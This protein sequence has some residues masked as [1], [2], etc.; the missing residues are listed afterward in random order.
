VAAWL[1]KEKNDERCR[2]P[3]GSC[4]YLANGEH[5][6]QYMLMIYHDEE[7]RAKMLEAQQGKI[8]QECDEFAQSLVKSDHFRAGARLQPTSM[9]TTVREKS[10]KRVT[11][12]GP[13]AESKE[14][15]AGYL[16]VECEDL[17]E[18]LAIAARFPSIRFGAAVEVRPVMPTSQ[19]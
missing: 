10:G 1:E 11:T 17:D 15:I 8:V 14:Q 13:F 6:M 3:G 19:T 16:L 9:A 7:L 4:D 5:A 12:D 2:S 18:A